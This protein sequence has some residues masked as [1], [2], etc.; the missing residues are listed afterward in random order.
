M[1]QLMKVGV[2]GNNCN[3]WPNGTSRHSALLPISYR[4]ARKSARCHYGLYVQSWDGAAAGIN[5]T[6]KG[7]SKGL[8]CGK[9]RGA[10]VGLWFSTSSR[11]APRSAHPNG[12]IGPSVPAAALSAG[13]L[14]AAE[15]L[16][17]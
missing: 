14:Y 7:K 4:R 5:P 2:I 6:K 12:V 17:A 13:T 1:Q 10:P 9:T 15:I 8:D 3:D 11:S 16:A